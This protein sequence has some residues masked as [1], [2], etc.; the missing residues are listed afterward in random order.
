MTDQKEREIEREEEEDCDYFDPCCDPKYQDL[1]GDEYY[2]EDIINLDPY[3]GPK[4]EEDCD[5]YDPCCDPR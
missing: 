1:C 3:D 5:Y 2:P 4:G